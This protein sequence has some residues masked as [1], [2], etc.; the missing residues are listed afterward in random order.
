[1]PQDVQ[2]FCLMTKWALGHL[3]SH[4]MDLLTNGLGRHAYFSA[5]NLVEDEIGLEIKWTWVG[6]FS[7]IHVKLKPHHL[8]L[9]IN[10]NKIEFH[11]NQ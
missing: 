5:S 4:Q 10:Y 6:Y 1:M 11:Y 7:H 3:N 2:S 8:L 9:I